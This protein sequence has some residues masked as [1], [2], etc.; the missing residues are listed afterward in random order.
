L[1]ASN[2]GNF[3]DSSYATETIRNR[4]ET[5]KFCGSQDLALASLLACKIFPSQ[6]T[7]E[8]HSRGKLVC[9]ARK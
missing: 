5:M 2:L 1:E 3:L 6:L 4:L 9:D 7:N 8:F